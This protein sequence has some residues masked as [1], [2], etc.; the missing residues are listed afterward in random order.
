MRLYAAVGIPT[1][2]AHKTGVCSI[3]PECAV[4]TK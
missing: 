1:A 3:S 4:L 2:V